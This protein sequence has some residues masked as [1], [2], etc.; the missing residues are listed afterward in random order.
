MYEN[1]IA[2]MER[3]AIQIPDF[4]AGLQWFNSAPLSFK[5]ELKGK[6]VLLDFWT[7]C[8]INCMHVLPDLAFLEKKY[9][10]AP[11]AFIGVHSAKFDNEKDP[12]NIRSAILR[13]DIEHPVVNDP[14]MSLWQKLGVHSWPSYV[15]VGPTGNILMLV[16]GEGMR[17][18]LDSFIREALENY[19]PSY[20]DA[21]P[22][23]ISLEKK[24]ISKDLTLSFPEN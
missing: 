16:S 8:C 10:G 12:E 22:L 3:R 7:Y 5:K 21:K 14:E 6:I 9:A 1:E 19:E 24:K 20:L 11:V 2:S 18:V 4:S 13:Y 15:I 23:P 17:N